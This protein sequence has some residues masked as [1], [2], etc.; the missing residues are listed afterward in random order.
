MAQRRRD[1]TGPRI[2]PLRL[3]ALVDGDPDDLR[4]EAMRDGERF[5]APPVDDRDLAGL[6]LD[7]CELSDVSLEGVDLRSA[8]VLE[9]AVT[10]LRATTLRAARSTWRDVQ[11]TAWRVGAAELWD[12]EWVGTALSD[13]RIGYLNLQGATL[14][15]VL[16]RDCVLDGLDLRDATCTRVAFVRC[17]IGTLDVLGGSFTHLDLR[18]SSV[19]TVDSAGALRGAIVD[20]DQVVELAPL[21]A[22][23]AGITVLPSVEASD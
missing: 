14:R 9:S 18:G 11:A 6:V 10:G 7:G 1:G 22:D 19:Q 5:V 4:A 20:G 21:L 13:S 16:L 23:A 3:G 2:D 12:S 15:D 8:R 17:R